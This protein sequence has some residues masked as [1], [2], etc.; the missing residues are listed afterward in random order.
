[1]F[2]LLATASALA[3]AAASTNSYTA[4]FRPETTGVSGGIQLKLSAAEMFYSYSVDFTNF[5]TSCD[6]SQGLT[7]HVH[8]FWDDLET[9]STTTCGSAGGHYDPYLACGSSSQDKDTLCKSLNRTAAD[10]YVYGCSPSEYAAGKHYACEAGDLSGKF[11]RMMPSET[12]PLVFIGQFVDP[13]PVLAV[14]F[15]NAEGIAKSW[16]SVVIHC[17]ADNSRLVCGAF[18]R[19][20]CLSKTC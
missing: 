8:S 16:A 7:Y 5:K 10:G 17:P 15:Y 13:N 19:D 2:K 11:G 14:N 20:K 3:T 12:N 18:I 4:S 6:L 1:M 9:S